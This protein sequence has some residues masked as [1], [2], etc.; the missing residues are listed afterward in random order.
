MEPKE[1][2]TGRT[3]QGNENRGLCKKGLRCKTEKRK[4]GAG[5]RR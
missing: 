2:K 3:G 1:T 4:D 5:K